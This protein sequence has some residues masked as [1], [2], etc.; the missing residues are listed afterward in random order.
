MLKT[1]EQHPKLSFLLDG[2]PFEQHAPK[3]TV[4]TDGDLVC[5]TYE[6]KDGLRLTNKFRAYPAY[7]ACEWVNEWE[8]TGKHPQRRHFGAVRRGR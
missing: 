3:V 8:H 7:D 2:V 4:K 1:M 6:F 5:T